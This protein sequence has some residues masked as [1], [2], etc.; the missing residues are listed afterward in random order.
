MLWKINKKKLEIER[1]NKIKEL[2]ELEKTKKGLKELEKEKINEAIVNTPKEMLLTHFLR[3]ACQL[4]KQ[5]NKKKSEKCVRVV[6]IL[7]K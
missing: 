4:I 2:K 7:N 3:H 1:I 5:G 6:E